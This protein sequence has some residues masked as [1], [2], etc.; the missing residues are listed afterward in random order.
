MTGTN[1]GTAEAFA[2]VYEEVTSLNNITHLSDALADGKVDFLNEPESVLGHRLLPSYA[3]V[4]RAGT[5]VPYQS[6]PHSLNDREK[7]LYISMVAQGKSPREIEKAL[8]KDLRPNNSPYFSVY[9]SECVNNPDHADLI[10]KL[11]GNSN[12]EIHRIR[13]IFLSDKWWE[14]IPH[15]LAAFKTS[16]LFCSSEP[17]G[18]Q[19]IASRE[20]ELAA[21]NG[22]GKPKRHFTSQKEKFPCVPDECPIYQANGCK[23]AGVLHFMILG[24][25]GTDIWRLT[26]TSWNGVRAIKE[27]IDRFHAALTRA[28]KSIVGMPFELFKVE[29]DISRMDPIKGRVRTKQWIPK[30]DCPEMPLSDLIAESAGF[31]KV[32]HKALPKVPTAGPA[33]PAPKIQFLHP[34]PALKPRVDR[35]EHKAPVQGSVESKKPVP[36]PPV[37]QAPSSAPAP[38]QNPVATPAVT[39]VTEPP[40]ERPAAVPQPVEDPN[41]IHLSGDIDMD[42]HE[43]FKKLNFSAARQKGQLEFNKD[44]LPTLLTNLIQQAK[45]K[46][47][48]VIEAP[49]KQE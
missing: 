23:F 48:E 26:T 2:D 11:Y 8:N 14:V 15:K 32:V 39:P 46:G 5:K 27:K 31:K 37:P 38:V 30:I 28:G 35:A 6:G 49:A 16:G 13:I 25:P 22:E 36:I 10:R 24:V 42:I 20:P 4:L 43:L 47:F 29:S 3:G 18:G 41:K 7:A 19:L 40:V 45:T 34:D 44:K 12:G 21:R 17:I 9:R 33:A 1:N